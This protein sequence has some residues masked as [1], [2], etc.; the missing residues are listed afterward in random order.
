MS[1]H[2]GSIRQ[3]IICP[4]TCTRVSA[5]NTG[6]TTKQTYIITTARTKMADVRSSNVESHWLFT[7]NSPSSH[8]S[9][10]CDRAMDPSGQ[11]AQDM[12][13][14]DV[15]CAAAGTRGLSAKSTTP[16]T[17]NLSNNLEKYR[18]MQLRRPNTVANTPPL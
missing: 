15:C 12:P 14:T 1:K 2:A 17:D 10:H 8:M 18:V 5:L 3:R 13:R 11:V 4:L 6:Q 7:Q 16:S 9:R